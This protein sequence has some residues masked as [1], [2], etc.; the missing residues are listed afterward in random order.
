VDITLEDATM[1]NEP[2]Q[3]A[4]TPLSE[5]EQA[6]RRLCF[7]KANHS[8][9]LEGMILTPEELADQEKVITGEWTHDELVEHYIKAVRRDEALRRQV[10]EVAQ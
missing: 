5:A 9:S 7:A 8:L 4:R 6:H 3:E 1:T 10:E 2:T